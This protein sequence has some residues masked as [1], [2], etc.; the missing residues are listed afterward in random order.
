[1]KDYLKKHYCKCGNRIGYNTF[2]YGMGRCRSCA[3]KGENNPRYGIHPWNYGKKLSKVGRLLLS[4]VHTGI[5]SPN[6]GKK[7]CYPPL[8][9]DARKKISDFMKINQ[10]G[11]NNSNWKGGTNHLPYPY[12][13]H[14]I[15]LEIRQKDNNQCQICNKYGDE[16]HH[17]DYNKQNANRNNLI[18]LCDSC[19]GMTNGNRDYW[20]AYFL[21]YKDGIHE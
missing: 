11:D 13:W 2:L 19:H 7:G 8:D 5:P 3:N 1:M 15:S 10:V 14:S 17:I 4:L 21:Y 9:V 12:N 20:Y 18:T 6:K 16:V